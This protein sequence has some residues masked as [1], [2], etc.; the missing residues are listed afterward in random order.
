[1]TPTHCAVRNRAPRRPTVR[2][3]I[4]IIRRGIFFFFFPVFRQSESVSRIY[5]KKPKKCRKTTIE[6]SVDTFSIADDK[7]G[8][9]SSES[10]TLDLAIRRYRIRRLLANAFG[11]GN[12]RIPPPA[13]RVIFTRP[14]RSRVRHGRSTPTRRETVGARDEKNSK[15]QKIA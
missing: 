2:K 15:S 7:V 4:F 3:Y 6:N 13:I 8:L 11:I 10:D 9:I 5:K 1:M 12:N 14:F